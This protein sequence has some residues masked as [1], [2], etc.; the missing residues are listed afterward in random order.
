MRYPSPPTHGC[1]II[2]NPLER[3][4]TLAFIVSSR[5]VDNTSFIF[6]L[7][8]T[9]NILCVPGDRPENDLG[10]YCMESLG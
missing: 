1:N 6:K 5:V 4:G 8:L 10:H 7:P 3:E 2:G 9:W